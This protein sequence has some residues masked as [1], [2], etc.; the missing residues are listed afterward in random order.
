MKWV[1]AIDRLV[2]LK[3]YAEGLGRRFSIDHMSLERINE[4]DQD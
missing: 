1:R 4:D 2:K 3:R